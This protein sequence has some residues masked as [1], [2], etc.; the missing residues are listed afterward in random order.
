MKKLL[1]IVVLGLLLSG[2][3]SERLTGD[4]DPELGEYGKFITTQKRLIYG[5]ATVKI[6]SKT[7]KYISFWSKPLYVELQE[8][9]N[10]AQYHCEKINLDAV[11]DGEDTAGNYEYASEITVNFLCK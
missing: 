1:G 8:L 7:P 4:K 10:A 11:I 2:C 9:T 5:S 3:A 6:I